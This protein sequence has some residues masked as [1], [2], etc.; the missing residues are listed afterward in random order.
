MSIK[1]DF[2][3]ENPELK[4]KHEL[5]LPTD[6]MYRFFPPQEEVLLADSNPEKNYRFIFNGNPKTEYEKKK[7]SQFLEYEIQKGKLNY[8]NNWLES[9][10]MRLLQA[11]E[12]DMK[13]AYKT[14][15]ENIN[16]RNKISKTINEKI[17]SLLNSGFLYVYGRDHHFR[18]IIIVSIKT[19]TNLIS[20]KK[21]AFEDIS[22]SIIYLLNYVIKYILIPGQIEN[23][24]ILVDFKG[25]GLS[26]V[27]EFKKILGILNTYRGRVFR[28]YIVN[29]SGFLKIAVK[30]ALK[31][32]G[33]SSTKKLK[34]LG[35]DELHKLQEIISP[36]NIP[37]NYGG[38]APDIIPGITKLFPPI[39]PSR[40]YAINGEKINIVSENDYREM[41]LYSK[42]FKPFVISP[43]YEQL[44]REE[45]EK[46]STKSSIKESQKSKNEKLNNEKEII[47]KEFQR[48]KTNS[49]EKERIKEIERKRL[50]EIKNKLMTQNRKN[51][52]SFLKEF[53]GLKHLENQEGTK[54]NNFSPV[55]IEEIKYF[56]KK[57]K[58][59]KKSYIIN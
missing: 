58:N 8:P 37:K 25:V 47:G 19:C 56:F 23:W 36:D 1:L 2:F 59:N 21:Y 50:L 41:C 51:I 31:V 22:E 38:S 28:N 7:L 45:N 30:T 35:S 20:Q 48:K 16:F 12:Y 33:S 44:W 4:E 43:K 17:I 9:D 52:M 10:T 53:E 6:E 5:A 42:P 54:Y 29:I 14:I 26:D 40:N 34:I 13:K 18:P 55:N 32:F 24:V 27:S 57:L 39:M 46:E 11:S 3:L 49:F 15:N